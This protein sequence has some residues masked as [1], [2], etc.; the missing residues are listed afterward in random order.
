MPLLSLAHP[1][2]GGHD[3]IAHRANHAL[4][5]GLGDPF[6]VIGMAG[7]G[8]ARPVLFK[9]I[10]RQAIVDA[11]EANGGNRTRAARQLGISLRTLQYRLKEYGLS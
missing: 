2:R 9:D 10:E 11:L 4:Q 7:E 6:H 5:H 3:R 1:A 8:P